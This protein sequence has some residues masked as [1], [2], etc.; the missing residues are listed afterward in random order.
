MTTR[1]LTF[2]LNEFLEGFE[3]VLIDRPDLI[4]DEVE[5]YKDF[6]GHTKSPLIFKVLNYVETHPLFT[7]NQRLR[8]FIEPCHRGK[9][10]ES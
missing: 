6:L 1:R 5:R 3:T 4:H 7:E 9:K 2:N 8:S 10:Q